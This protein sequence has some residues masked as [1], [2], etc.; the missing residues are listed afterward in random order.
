MHGDV[1]KKI[2]ETYFIREKRERAKFAL[3]SGKKRRPFIWGIS[4]HWIQ[5]RCL[6]RIQEP[7]ASFET[8]LDILQKHGFPKECYVLSI[9]RDTDGKI[10]PLGQALKQ[11]VG[12]GPALL[13]A[14]DA[15]I[16][17]LE[18]ELGIGAPLRYIL[19]P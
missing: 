10:L 19:N 17:Y 8:V 2:I 6:K 7:I 14:V 1:E 13:T 11:I 5:N 3:A 18:G 16:G 12:A 9:D 4:E 15:G